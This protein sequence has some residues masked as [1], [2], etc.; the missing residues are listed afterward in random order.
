MSFMQR[1]NARGRDVVKEN[2]LLFLKK[3][4]AYGNHPK[5]G[6]DLSLFVRH[7]KFYIFGGLPF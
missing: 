6:D 7:E 4:M 2:C 1:L 5:C 3:R